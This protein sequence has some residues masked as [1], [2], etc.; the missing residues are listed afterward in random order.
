MKIGLVLFSGTFFFFGCKSTS[1]SDGLESQIHAANTA[2]ACKKFEDKMVSMGVNTKTID[3]DGNTIVNDSMRVVFRQLGKE[4][5]T[6]L[7]T[8][9]EELQTVRFNDG[10]FGDM[11]YAKFSQKDSECLWTVAGQKDIDSDQN[12]TTWVVNEATGIHFMSDFV[13]ETSKSGYRLYEDMLGDGKGVKI[14][15][16]TR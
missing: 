15:E 9:G 11:Y 13:L 2:E 16:W 12:S 5:A 10:T 4:K 6:I 3:N 1:S 7:F 8:P 14:V